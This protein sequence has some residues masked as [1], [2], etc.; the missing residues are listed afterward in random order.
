MHRFLA[1]LVMMQG[2]GVEKIE[3]S[4]RPRAAGKS[5]YTNWSRLKKTV[6]DLYAVK[7]L[8][9]RSK[10]YGVEEIND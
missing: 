5:K 6:F 1:S 4:H 10:V 2:G 9:S 7:W 3:V 8:K